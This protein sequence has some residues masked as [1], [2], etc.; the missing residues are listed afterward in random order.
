MNKRNQNTCIE[1]NIL[2]VAGTGYISI[3]GFCPGV[4]PGGY[5]LGGGHGP[6]QRKYGLSIDNLLE[7]TMVA[8]DGAIVTVGP[9]GLCY[10]STFVRFNLHKN[11]I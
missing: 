2:Q 1:K 10:M 6:M 4:T 3:S 7:V 9:N 11:D 5:M 8:L